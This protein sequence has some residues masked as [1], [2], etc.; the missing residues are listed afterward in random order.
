MATSFAILRLAQY[1]DIASNIPHVQSKRT[2]STR[3]A[4]M[5]A[6]EEVRED[7]LE[8]AEKC[9]EVA[10]ASVAARPP[11]SCPRYIEGQVKCSDAHDEWLSVIAED[12][13]MNVTSPRDLK[14]NA[15]QDHVAAGLKLRQHMDEHAPRHR[16][17]VCACLCANAEVHACN[18][19]APQGH[20]A[21]IPNRQLLR[22]D[23]A[24]S[25]AIPRD[26]QTTAVLDDAFDEADVQEY[27]LW[28]DETST[29][30]KH[31]RPQTNLE[32][33]TWVNVC[34][35]CMSA[36]K[37]HSDKAPSVP[38]RS[39]ARLDPG[40]PDMD[41]LTPLEALVVAPLRCSKHV[42][43]LKGAYPHQPEDQRQKAT[44]GHVVAFPNV[45]PRAIA[46]SFPLSP[47]DIAQHVSV[48]LITNT[49]SRAEV[50]KK[51]ASSK[52]CHI[53]VS[54]WCFGKCLLR[55]CFGGTVATRLT[56]RTCQQR[57]LYVTLASVHAYVLS[58]RH[59]PCGARLLICGT[60]MR[61]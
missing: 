3:Q 10:R 4:A 44:R 55:Q 30:P 5:A 28:I 20:H 53:P 11:P 56:A 52:V 1:L 12:C 35:E 13:G 40:L 21:S 57:C 46:S 49:T 45:H 2:I 33:G 39:L 31:R 7:I 15:L 58:V 51:V 6:K 32:G 17:A 54:V 41:L 8:T 23:G 36:L 48:V 42:F 61:Y 43:A 50:E 25:D 27:C 59:S 37:G 9:V 38:P 16:C 19:S 34:K 29:V 22:A 60:D 47:D 14:A 18:A 24:K 26:G